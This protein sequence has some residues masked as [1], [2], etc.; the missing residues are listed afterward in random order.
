[1]STDRPTAG[2]PDLTESELWT[3]GY[4]EAALI[5]DATM[6]SAAD[7]RLVEALRLLWSHTAMSGPFTSSFNPQ[8]LTEFTTQLLLPDST[9]RPCGWC[10]VAPDRWTLATTIWVREEAG[11]E[12]LFDWLYLAL[13]L[14]S[15]GS[16]DS[17]VDGY[18]FGDTSD[19]RSWLEPL[20]ARLADISA[21]VMTAC[22]A[23]LGLIGFEIAGLVSQDELRGKPP[24]DTGRGYVVR[25]ADGSVNYV[26]PSVWR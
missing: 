14:A 6:D 11:D 21:P 16:L 8:R 19:C 2:S 1:M 3:G 13:P 25:K 10:Q 23:R 24:L 5:F 7:Q 18:P 15:L 20:M 9:V 26:S 12:P 17:R 22:D 4:L